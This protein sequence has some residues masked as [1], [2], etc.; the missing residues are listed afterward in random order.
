MNVSC[1]ER[2]VSEFN[3]TPTR[4]LNC[5]VSGCDF[6]GVLNDSGKLHLKCKSCNYKDCHSCSVNKSLTFETHR[7]VE[8]LK[9]YY[10]NSC[11]KISYTEDSLYPCSITVVDS[12]N[13]NHY[14]ANTVGKTFTEALI[15]IVKTWG[16]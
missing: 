10:T 4:C 9:S 16:K 8:T 3:E 2:Y 12:S 1:N 5:L 15:D 11:V 7:V 14:Y 13:N 6:K